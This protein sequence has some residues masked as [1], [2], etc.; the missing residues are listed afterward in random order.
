MQK[1][2]K[3]IY[4]GLLMFKVREAI[5]KDKFSYCCNHIMVNSIFKTISKLSWGL[6]IQM[7][8]YELIAC[9][10]ILI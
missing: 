8:K 1:P 2:I 10:N 5:L 3:K 9:Y 4:Y 7:K 6:E